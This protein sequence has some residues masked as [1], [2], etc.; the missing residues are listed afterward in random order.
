MSLKSLFERLP[1][2]QTDSED[3]L[4]QNVIVVMREF[5]WTLD[6]VKSLPIP[7]FIE[8]LGV[9]RKEGEKAEREMSKSKG[10][11]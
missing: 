3:V 1:I 8:I 6:E 5:G 7:A 2:R 9:L 4:V 11:R 10:K